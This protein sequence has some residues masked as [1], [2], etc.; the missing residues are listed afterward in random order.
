MHLSHPIV[1]LDA[2]WPTVSHTSVLIQ[3]PMSDGVVL[4]AAPVPGVWRP[5]LLS[6]VIVRKFRLQSICTV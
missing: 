2:P 5:I 1:P 3:L 4:E 6:A